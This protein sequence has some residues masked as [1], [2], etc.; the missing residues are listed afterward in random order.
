MQPF[1]NILQTF[2]MTGTEIEA[3]LEQQWVTGHPKSRPVLRLGISNGFSYSASASAS[4]GD[5]IDPASITLNG[6][7]VDPAATYRVAASSFLADGGDSYLAFRNGTPRTGGQVD[8]DG[9][10]DYRGVN[11]PVGA[12]SH[13][14]QR[15]LRILGSRQGLQCRHGHQPVLMTPGL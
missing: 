6:A 11:S 10:V 8:L 12:P 1:G 13:R 9:L 2:D 7:V 3:V 14:G 5:K 4:F 15:R